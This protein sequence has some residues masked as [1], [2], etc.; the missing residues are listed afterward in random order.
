MKKLTQCVSLLL[1]CLMVLAIPVSANSRSMEASHYFAYTSAY[2]SGVTTT[3]F[4]VCF[5]VTAVDIMDELGASVI[6]VER[7][8][9]GVNWETVHTRT[10][11]SYP[12]MIGENDYD[13]NYNFL[14]IGLS[15]YSYRAYIEFY[16]KDDTGEAYYGS[17]T[18]T[19]P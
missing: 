1:V 13:H 18:Q 9:D 12:D 5:D 14:Y 17:Y 8:S 7:S 16:A 6:E 4:K 2:L 19:F 15:G 11:E 10:K 3:A